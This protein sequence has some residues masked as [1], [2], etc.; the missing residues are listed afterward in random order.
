VTWE[1]P[2]PRTVASSTMTGAAPWSGSSSVDVG[3]TCTRRVDWHRSLLALER[4]DYAH[5]V[6]RRSTP[7]DLQIRTLI[8]RM[9]RKNPT[10]VGRRIQAELRFL[11]YE[12][13]PP[14]PS[15]NTCAGPSGPPSPAWRASLA[16]HRREI[17]AVDFFVVPPLAFRLLF[18]F[19]ILRHDRREL[20]HIGVTDQPTATWAA[21]QIVHAFPDETGPTYLL[22]DR[23][24]VYGA[25]FQRRVERMGMRRVVIAPR[26]PWQ[27][28]FAQRVIG[29]IRRECLDSSSCSTNA[30]R[31][32]CFARTSATTTLR[33][34]TRVS[35]A[36]AHAGA[37]YIRSHPGV[38]SQS[39]RSAG[40]ITATSAP[41]DR[42]PSPTARPTAII[43]P[44]R[45]VMGRYRH[46]AYSQGRRPCRFRRE[47]S[48]SLC[49]TLRL[50]GSPFRPGQGFLVAFEREHQR[51][52]LA[53]SSHISHGLQTTPFIGW[54][55]VQYP[56]GVAS[57][58]VGTVKQ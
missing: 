21:Q 48:Q 53:E 25:D 7:I 33:G 5:R 40:F 11:G 49:E 26:A 27:N 13:S 34:L 38:S 41:P 24:A 30:T 43:R 6:V 32:A 36:T 37:R 3:W 50:G 2:V 58:R 44:G 9:A 46:L 23:D 18:G 39:P 29:S 17:A 14:S 28:P 42:P 19:V 51:Q 1:R 55:K 57:T 54:T 4:P 10:W 15:P 12:V 16:A 47:P 35:V 22:P 56:N 8:R 20:L 31:V 52:A 45:S